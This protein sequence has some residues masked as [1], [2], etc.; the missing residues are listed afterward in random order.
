MPKFTNGEVPPVDAI[1]SGVPPFEAKIPT[2]PPAAAVRPAK[3]VEAVEVGLIV[4][5]MGPGGK[6]NELK[7]APVCAIVETL[8]PLPEKIP[9]PPL[10]RTAPNDAVP[11]KS[12]LGA[13]I[14]DNEEVPPVVAIKL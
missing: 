14:A 6:L 2:P 9:L 10:V 5:T 3:N 13:K 4:E 11:L 7:N 1:V 12:R 8:P